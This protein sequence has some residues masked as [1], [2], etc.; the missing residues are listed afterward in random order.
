MEDAAY[1]LSEGIITVAF[2]V[3]A[4]R[5]LRRSFRTHAAPE[6]LLG[7]ASAGRRVRR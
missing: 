2:L 6:Q 1:F 7:R 5:L 4:A 3:I